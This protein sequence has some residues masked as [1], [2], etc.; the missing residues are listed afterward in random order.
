[1]AEPARANPVNNAGMQ[2]VG[3]SRVSPANFTDHR[4]QPQRLFHTILLARPGMNLKGWADHQHRERAHLVASP[5]KTPC[6]CQARSP[7][8]QD[9]VT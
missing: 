6:R 2:H 5:F 1:M 9:G 7:A 8:Y 4:A 3:R